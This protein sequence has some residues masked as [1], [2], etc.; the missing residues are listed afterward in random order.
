MWGVGAPLGSLTPPDSP[1]DLGSKQQ[2]WTWTGSGRDTGL[3]PLS[4]DLTKLL[5]DLKQLS[6]VPGLQAP[7]SALS[8]EGEILVVGSLPG[9]VL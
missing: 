6:Q 9:C 1:W 5:P 8:W 4:P 3:M 2:S 7:H